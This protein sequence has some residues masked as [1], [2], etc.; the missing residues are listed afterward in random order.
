MKQTQADIRQMGPNESHVGMCELDSHADTCCLGMNFVPIYFTGRI[1]DVAPFLTD[2][3][4]Q[5][6]VQICSGATAY[7][8]GNGGTYILII[9]EAI[10]FGDQMQHSLINP[11]QVRAYGVSLCDDPTDPNCQLG[12]DVQDTFIPFTMSGTTCSFT[13]RTPT[14]WELENCPHLEIT[15]DAEWNPMHLIFHKTLG[16]THKISLKLEYWLTT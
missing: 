1:C 13:T 15:L 12:M 4:N 7:D 14:S 5:Q 9:N 11:N 6:G 8:N 16:T 2:L 10:W 3:P